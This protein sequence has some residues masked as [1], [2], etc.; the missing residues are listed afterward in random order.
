MVVPIFSLIKKKL[1]ARTKFYATSFWKYE[2]GFGMIH[3]LPQINISYLL[4]FTFA[5][6]FVFT[7]VSLRGS[8]FPIPPK[9]LFHP[10][11]CT[12]FGLFSSSEEASS[13]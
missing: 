12:T 4:L 5:T 6:S 2:V 10:M 9:T 7:G 8:K 13:L 3:S 11:V 1:V